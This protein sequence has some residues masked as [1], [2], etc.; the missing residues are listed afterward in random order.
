MRRIVG[1][2]LL[3][4]MLLL[5]LAAPVS[6][7]PP[8]KDSTSGEFL[9]AFSFSCGPSTCT[10]TFVDVFPVADGVIVVC[11]GEF[12]FNIRSG[13]LI[14][15]ESGCSDPVSSSALA[16]SQD[17]SSASLSPTA[18]TFFECGPRGCVAGD[19]VTVSAQLTGVGPVFTQTDRSTFSDGTCT[20]RFSS[21]TESRSATGTMTISGETTSVDG[22]IGTGRF[23]FME[24][25]R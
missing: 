16:V 5:L 21:S 18:V 22:N 13:R 15:G 10:D 2:L 24:R 12:T 6:A 23:T 14:S 11:V 19:T 7:A 4:P 8:L 17:L 25:C 9:S 3:V 20:F 1:P